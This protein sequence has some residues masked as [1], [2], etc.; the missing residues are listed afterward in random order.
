MKT[1][2]KTHSSK[3]VA[4]IH[5]KKIK[6]RGGKVTMT[7]VKGGFHIEY[8]FPEKKKTSKKATTTKKKKYDVISPD[9]FSIRIGVPLFNSIKERDDYFKM[10]KN[11][12]AQQGYYSSVPY[13]RIHLADLADYCEWI[14][15]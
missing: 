9:G 14:E 6:D 4:E 1:Y 13:G 2:T 3:K 10:W 5:L 11:R 7:N 15:V 8:S 12:F